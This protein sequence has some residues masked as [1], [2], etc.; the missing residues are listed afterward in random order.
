MR[1]KTIFGWSCAVVLSII[2]SLLLSTYAFLLL[3]HGA[4]VPFVP[5]LFAT[6]LALFA[7]CCLI[8]FRACRKRGLDSSG[9]WRCAVIIVL[10]ALL[11]F[12]MVDA[13]QIE[14]DYV[15][16]DIVSTN[17]NILESYDTLML[18]RKDGELKVD[19]TIT[20]QMYS[21]LQTNSVAHSELIYHAWDNIT[22]ARS[23]IEKLDTY[24][25]IADLTPEV[26]LSTNTPILNF[27]ALRSIGWTYAAYARLMTA[28]G[29]PDKGVQ[30]LATLH[31]VTRKAL[32]HAAILIDKMIWI[33]IAN[34]NIETAFSVIQDPHCTSNTLGLLKQAFPSISEDR[35]SLQRVLI[36]EYVGLKAI[37]DADLKPSNFFDAFVMVEVGEP[38]RVTSLLRRTTSSLVYH[39]TFRK[40]RTFRDLRKHYDLLI[41]GAAKHPPNMRDADIFADAYCHR[42][43]IRN[44]GGWYLVSI[45]VPSFERSC[46]A[47]VKTK[48]LSDL[49][50]IEIGHRLNQPVVL[51]DYYSDDAYKRD[52]QTDRVFSVGPDG[53]PH[54]DDDI[55]LGKK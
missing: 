27:V 50:A 18:L 30:H 28:E 41:D 10:S 35:V 51:Q 23:V 31:S 17:K 4:L 13:P 9:W 38:Q 45:A 53:M 44:P 43:D 32:P 14:K 33:A 25:G 52:N 20:P 29:H 15:L 3:L 5:V 21:Q 37:C 26:E 12:L 42:L 39:L 55:I 46:E 7:G 8:V 19:A 2:Y 54:T 47:A 22:E 49:L 11:A 1:V 16:H 40:N 24:L 48:V 36:G 34:N 6:L